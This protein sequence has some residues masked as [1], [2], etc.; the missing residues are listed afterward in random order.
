MVIGHHSSEVF[1]EIVYLKKCHD[2][3]LFFINP[4]LGPLREAVSQYEKTDF[5]KKGR[6]G[7]VE[8][9]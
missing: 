2:V 7:Q 5:L 1:N 8:K 6:G 9:I 4:S 3:Y